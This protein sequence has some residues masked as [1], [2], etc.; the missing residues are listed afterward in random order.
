[1]LN[2]EYSGDEDESITANYV[3][4]MNY[5]AYRLHLGRTDEEIVLHRFGQL[6]QQWIVDMYAIVEQTLLGDLILI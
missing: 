3:T 5:F 6:F 4:A 2:K 1:Q